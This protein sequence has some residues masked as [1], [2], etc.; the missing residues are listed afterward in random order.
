MAISLM[1][2]QTD[3]VTSFSMLFL[4]MGTASFSFFNSHPA[5]P[6]PNFNFFNPLAQVRN[7]MFKSFS[8]PPQARIDV[9]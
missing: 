6:Q 1:F 7:C 3:F 9:S 2:L 5:T 4:V 8:P